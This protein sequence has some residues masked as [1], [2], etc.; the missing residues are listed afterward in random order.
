MIQRVDFHNPFD[1]G[2]AYINVEPASS[3]S[4]LEVE[5]KDGHILFTG[6][7]NEKDRIYGLGESMHGL[8]KR[9]YRYV[10]F[11]T[12][13]NNHR[14]SMPSMY[15][16][17]NFFVVASEQQ[18]RGFFFDYPGRL[19]IDLDSKHQNTFT[20]EAETNDIRVYEIQGKTPYEVVKEF[21]KLIGPSY[22]PPLWAFGFGQSRWGYDSLRTVEKVIE[23]YKKAGMP[24]DYVCLDIDHMNKY[25]DFSVDTKRFGNLQLK[26]KNIHLV[27]I[28]DA[29]IKIEPGNPVYEEGLKNNFY[30]TD[31]DGKPFTAY[32]W[33]G[34]TNFPD[35]LKAEARTWFGSLYKFYTDKGIEGFWNDMNEPSI[36]FSEESL[37]ESEKERLSDP[38]YQSGSGHP[39]DYKRF[40]H[41]VNGKKI[42]HFYL[43]NL[44][45]MKMVEASNEGLSKL[46]DKRFLLFSRASYIGS[47]R[48]AGIW[49]GDNSSTWFMLQR[50]F[51]MLPGLNM[52]GFLFSGMDTG[53]FMGNCTRKLLLRWLAVSV[54][55]PL[56]RDHSAKG[57]IH[58]ECYR[59]AGKS[60][61]RNVLSLRYK[62]LPYLYSEFMKAA[63][64]AD[65]LIKP[66]A[67][68]FDKDPQC[69]DVQDQLMVGESIMIAPIMKKDQ[70]SRLVYLP[71]E[72]TM[73]DYYDRSFHAKALS[74]GSHRIKIPLSHVVFFVRKNHLV[75]VSL[76]GGMSVSEVDF[77]NLSFLGDGTSYEYYRDDGETR[78]AGLEKIAEIKK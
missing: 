40:Y 34:A 64:R 37:K 30:C 50:G 26:E 58:Q 9:G 54:F 25:A 65:M 56:F 5:E 47:H 49:T 15:G 74:Q 17:H 46:L 51:E 53:G 44:Y 24:L 2:A 78:E 55:T 3:L 6:K 33:P 63:L 73:V 11:N 59:F 66:L 1:T 12:D 36:F 7:L 23:N 31:K 8:N 61:F 43:H 13:D 29:A 21:L 75:P 41:D 38:L 20:V 10:Q 18:A 70:D 68:V 45:G 16:A 28:V 4:F 62:L 27:P 71:E 19:I 57:T 32:V 35:F 42:N 72:M 48:Y 67:F 76:K 39:S 14:D 77:D 60:S 52:C 22:L 69:Q